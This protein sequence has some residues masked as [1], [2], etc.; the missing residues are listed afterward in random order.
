MSDISDLEGIFP[1][2]LRWNAENGVL[3][4]STFDSA[5]GERG[6]EEIE[7]GS[8]RAK[9]AFDY[10]TRQRGYGLIRV[11]FYDMRLSP[12]G[13]RPPEWTDEMKK[14]GYKPAIGFWVWNPI[15]GELRFDTNGVLLVRVLSGVWD[16]YRTFKEAAQGMVPIVHFVDRRE[17]FVKGV[18]EMFWVP[19][20]KIIGFVL[21]DKIAPFA[22]RPPTVKS[23]LAIDSQVSFALL[24]APRSAGPSTDVRARLADK[25]GNTAATPVAKPTSA[26]PKRGS[27]R[28]E[29]PEPVDPIQEPP[30]PLKRGSLDD[31]LDDGLPDD[32]IPEL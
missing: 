29:P 15:L 13:S 9:F 8:Q 23:P 27:K 11:G 28:G 30:K 22:M 19:I 3:G 4:H 24:E 21:R 25:L 5:T 14:D 26:R 6:I 17:E 10:A 32:P 2:A 12:V 31:F 18:G 1:I 20:I 16:S 7:L